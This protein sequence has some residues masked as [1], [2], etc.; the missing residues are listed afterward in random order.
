MDRPPADPSR[1]W[2]SRWQRIPLYRR[3]LC[4]LV[5]GVIA[6]ALL[7]PKAEVLALPSK[8]ILQLL[9]ALAPAL[10]LAAIVHA[11]MN[12][13]FEKGTAGRMIRLL[14]LNTL[15]AIGIGLLVANLLRPGAW[16]SAAGAA[17]RTGHGWKPPEMLL[18]FLENVPKSFLGPLSDQGKVIGVIFIAVGIGMAL[19]KIGDQPVAR[20][21]DLVAVAF[22]TLIEMLHWII[23]LIPLAVFGIVASL[24]GTKGLAAFQALG[25]FVLAV[26]ARASSAGRTITSCASGSVPGCGPGFF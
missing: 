26:L 11:L 14:L 1:G 25:A 16:A 8:L 19:R 15:V 6:G 18:Q 9:G 13:K 7:G 12:A 2:L 4:G 5:L 10:I 20:V 23:A 3:I 22:H 24:L 17:Q 21:S